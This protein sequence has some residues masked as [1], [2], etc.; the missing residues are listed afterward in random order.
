MDSKIRNEDLFR[1]QS[2]YIMQDDNLQPLLTVKEAMGV[3]ACLKLGPDVTN[4]ERQARVC[5]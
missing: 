2:C 1:K 3:A 5:S 4:E